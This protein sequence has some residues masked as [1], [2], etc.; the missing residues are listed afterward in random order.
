MWNLIKIVIPKIKFE[1]EN[2][3]YSMG[4]E[5]DTVN[6]IEKECNGKLEDCCKKLFQDWLTTGHGRTPKTWQTVIERIKDVDSLVA[7][8]E[9]IS[10]ELGSYIVHLD[11]LASY[12][13]SLAS[14]TDM[15]TNPSTDHEKCEQSHDITGKMV[16]LSLFV[17]I[18]YLLSPF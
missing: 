17:V 7:A 11:K 2:F 15:S 16:K 4:Y 5:P 18:F 1:W 12:I 14:G 13:L 6:A 9:N 3:A 10:V 8:A